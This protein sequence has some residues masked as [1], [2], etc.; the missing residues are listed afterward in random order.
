MVQQ[1]HAMSNVRIG[2]KWTSSCK[3]RMSG[4]FCGLAESFLIT[5]VDW[6]IITWKFIIFFYRGAIRKLRAASLL[7][8]WSE[9]VVWVC[10]FWGGFVLIKKS[11]AHRENAFKVWDYFGK[12]FSNTVCLEGNMWLWLMVIIY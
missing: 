5:P 11:F 6:T 7:I 9:E 12:L 2:L 4:F 8:W 3:F 1:T 10:A